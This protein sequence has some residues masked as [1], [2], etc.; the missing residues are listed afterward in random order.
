MIYILINSSNY[1]DIILNKIKRF[2]CIKHEH[3]CVSFK[4]NVSSI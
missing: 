1:C 2:L 3:S 4:N